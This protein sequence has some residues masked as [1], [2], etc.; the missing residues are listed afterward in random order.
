MPVTLGMRRN[1]LHIVVPGGR[2]DAGCGH[3]FVQGATG[4][5]CQAIEI[6]RVQCAHS[7]CSHS[8]RVSRP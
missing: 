1:P 3:A 4:M 7:S 6:A 5:R 2:L 8:L